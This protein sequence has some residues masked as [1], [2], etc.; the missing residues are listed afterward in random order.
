MSNL[1]QNASDLFDTL[2]P[3]ALAGYKDRA[4]EI[5]AVIGFN[6]LGTD[7]GNWVLDCASAPPRILKEGRD[8]IPATTCT[9]EI[10][11]ADFKE[12][13]TDHNKGVDYYF[14]N[15]IRVTGDTQAAL[16]LGLFFEI[17]RPQPC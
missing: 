1:P 13:M 7:G 6:I 12:L 11:H 17:T 4:R 9:I 16:H 15:K 2:L 14:S 8:S 5:N 10:E 3:V